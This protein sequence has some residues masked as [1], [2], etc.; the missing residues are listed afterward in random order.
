TGT[1][2]NSSSYYLSGASVGS[3]PSTTLTAGRFALFS[4]IPTNPALSGP[5]SDISKYWVGVEDR[6]YGNPAEGNWGDFNDMIFSVPDVPEPGFYG[7]LAL[8]LSA[9]AYKVRRRKTAE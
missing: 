8:G 6:L 5:G 9:L 1:V 2:L 7:V 3:N 4:E